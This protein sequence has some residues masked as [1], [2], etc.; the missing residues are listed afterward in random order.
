MTK[1]NSKLD[2][3]PTRR[4]EPVFWLIHIFAAA[5]WGPPMRTS[6]TKTRVAEPLLPLTACPRGLT[7]T[8]P[9]NIGEGRIE[10]CQKFFDKSAY[11]RHD[12]QPPAD[13]DIDGSIT[14]QD[15]TERHDGTCLSLTLPECIATPALTTPESRTESES[16]RLDRLQHLMW[17]HSALGFTHDVAAMSQADLNG[18]GVYLSRVDKEAHA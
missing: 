16:W 1:A 9:Q 8:C 17:K 6:A 10:L 18:L 11:S 12:Q 13:G 15:A 14:H 3:Q 4:T 2:R 7:P 5:G